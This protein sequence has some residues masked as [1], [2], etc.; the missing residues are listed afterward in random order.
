M[1]PL[2][3]ICLIIA[4]TACHTTRDQRCEQ[5]EKAYVAYQISTTVREPSQQE[6]DYAHAA[7]AFLTLYCGWV[8][9][10]G[11]DQYGVPIIHKEAR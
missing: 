3:T 9:T 2:I 7:V 10:K 4:L 8:K 5:Y 1:K 11:V 6:L